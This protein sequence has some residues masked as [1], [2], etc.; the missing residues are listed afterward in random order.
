[1]LRER[2]KKLTSMTDQAQRGSRAAKGK[3]SR[4][5]EQIRKQL[6]HPGPG[7]MDELATVDAE[8]DFAKAQAGPAVA[9]EGPGATAI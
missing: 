8:G 3:A 1:M 7:P 4:G 2:V 5:D 6:K 9:L